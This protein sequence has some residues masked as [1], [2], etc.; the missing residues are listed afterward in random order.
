MHIFTGV[1]G[2]VQA[3]DVPGGM[4]AMLKVGGFPSGLVI[5]T[6]FGFG[7]SANVQFLETLRNRIYVYPF[8]EK[9][10]ASKLSGMVF[11]SACSGASSS[12]GIHSVLSYYA[13][14]SV[15]KSRDTLRIS[16]GGGSSSASVLR[17]FIL[18]VEVSA[19]D[20]EKGF[21]FFDINLATL[22]MGYTGASS[23]GSGSSSGDGP[24]LN[25]TGDFKPPLSGLNPSGIGALESAFG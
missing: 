7:Q 21:A 1:A 19:R 25:K 22:P 11:W 12:S 17:A 15:S 9:M 3:L 16:L 23:D 24:K 6:G 5:I 20:P 2:S 10:G 14:N 18:G 13:E 4:P 8:G